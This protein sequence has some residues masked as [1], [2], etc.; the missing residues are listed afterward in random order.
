M[1]LHINLKTNT[2]TK[3]LSRKKKHHNIFQV[4]KYVALTCEFKVRVPLIPLT[5][6]YQH[7]MLKQM[8]KNSFHISSTSIARAAGSQQGSL[9]TN[10][11]DSE[12]A[13]TN[14]SGAEFISTLH[15]ATSP[16]RTDGCQVPR[17]QQTLP[18]CHI[19]AGKRPAMGCAQEAA[20]AHILTQK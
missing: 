9:G 20:G 11:G 1:S 3:L 5:V 10:P 7:V 6:V 13:P 18:T 4:N 2:F 17:F 8:K 16:A 15:H 12:P 19:Q 14:H